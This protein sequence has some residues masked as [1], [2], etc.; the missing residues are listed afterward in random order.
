MSVDC[1]RPSEL[2]NVLF[3]HEEFDL[4]SDGAIG[5]WFWVL[6]TVVIDFEFEGLEDVG[7]VVDVRAGVRY[8]V[9]LV[10]AS[11]LGLL[12]RLIAIGVYI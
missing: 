2:E 12:L 5:V 8:S 10:C 7:A 1:C 11:E 3:L 6:L 9:G 4:D